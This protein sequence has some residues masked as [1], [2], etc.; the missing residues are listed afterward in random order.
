MTYQVLVPDNVHPSALD[1]LNAAAGLQIT[2]PGQMKR[3]ELLAALPNATLDIWYEDGLTGGA[4]GVHA[5]LL[6]L[7]GIELPAAADVYLCGNNGFVQAVR[8]QLMALG[9]PA[10]RVHSELFSPN[11]W[12]LS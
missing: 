3:D 9:V 5:G 11:D 4:P 8:N 1:V 6:T 7:D 2:A 10:A 12:L